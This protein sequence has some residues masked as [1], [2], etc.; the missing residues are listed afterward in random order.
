LATAVA[1]KDRAAPWSAERRG[2]IALSTA[3][4]DLAEAA[5]EAADDQRAVARR[6]RTMQAQR[7]RGWSWSRILDRE[8][9]PGLVA[10]LRRSGR[11]VGEATA[12]FTRR[13]AL[14]LT[15]EGETRRHIGRRLGVTHQRVTAMLDG[16]GGNAAGPRRGE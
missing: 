9:A 6:A 16:H 1:G 4:D 2:R 15:E 13:L 7:D 11:R 12:S 3:L 14:G 10:L 8:P 5:D